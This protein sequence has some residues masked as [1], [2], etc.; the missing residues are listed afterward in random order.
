MFKLITII[1]K[2]YRKLHSEVSLRS[3]TKGAS[4]TVYGDIN[5]INRRNLTIGNDCTFNHGTYINAF[6][7]ITIGSDVT[8]SAHS[9]IISTGIDYTAW[10]KGAKSHLN[11]S[12]INIGNHVWIG[13][14][15]QIIGNVTISGEYV[16]VAAGA[17]VTHDITESNCIVA[18][19]PARIIKRF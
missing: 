8:I 15:A 9:C 12:G 4:N 11:N 14:N 7:P 1:R 13:S 6:N 18:G 2:Y 10:S 16:V 17:I 5:V 19:V 3:V